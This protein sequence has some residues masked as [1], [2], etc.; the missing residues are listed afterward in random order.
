METSKTTKTVAGIV[1]CTCSFLGICQKRMSRFLATSHAGTLWLTLIDS[2]IRCNSFRIGGLEFS[3]YIYTGTITAMK[4][5]ILGFGRE[6]RVA[7]EYWHKAGSDITVCDQNKNLDLPK[8]AKSHLGTDYLKNLGGFDLLV[9]TPALHP[10]HI[11]EANPETPAILDKVTTVTDE[12]FQVCP[13]KNIIGV[14]GTKGKGTTSSLIAHMLETAGQRVHLAGNIGKPAL[15]L[16]EKNIKPDDWVVLELSNFQLVDLKHS[17]SIAVCLMI[18]PEHLNWHPDVDEYLAAKKQLFA[19]Q[20]EDGLSVYYA[21]NKY[22]QSL[23]AA[24]PGV[25]M[26]YM[27]A[28]GAEVLEEETVVID[29]KTI[30]KTDEIR[31]LGKHNWQNV[32]AAVTVVWQIVPD[33]KILHR[34]ITS[35]AGLPHRLELVREVDGVKYYNDSFASQP[36]ATIAALEAVVGAKV[37][38]VGGFDRGLDLE[39]LARACLLHRTDIRRLVLVG[40]SAQRLESELKAHGFT[41]YDILADKQ[42]EKIVDHARS[43]SKP[44]DS[45]VLSPGFASFDMFKDFEERG[46]KYKAYVNGLS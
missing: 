6:G 34:A 3:E 15:E 9:R 41:N 8:G 43:V 16:L 23:A 45:V 11:T 46:L 24:S 22:S 28:P 32:C 44:G 5:A 31:L 17:P 35:F 38:I 18:E 7:Y 42:I 13:T 36:S 21:P 33:P 39:A 4:V 20:T 27:A 30:C 25:L 26:P 14:T 29:H 40:A 1:I 10:R 12:F 19:N 2:P 37:M